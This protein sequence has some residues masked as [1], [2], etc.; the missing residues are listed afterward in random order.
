MLT[1]W[2][3]KPY[4]STPLT[5]ISMAMYLNLESEL[6]RKDLWPL[7]M[8]A[9]IKEEANILWTKLMFKAITL[10]NISSTIKSSSIL[11]ETNLEEIIL[12]IPEVTMQ[13]LPSLELLEGWQQAL[14]ITIIQLNNL[15]LGIKTLPSQL[16]KT[17]RHKEYWCPHKLVTDWDKTSKSSAIKLLSLLDQEITFIKIAKEFKISNYRLQMVM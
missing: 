3:P 16:I 12:R 13:H 11:K 10:G 14:T 1:W 5:W 4:S 15:M 2:G 8:G 17:S 7:N 6:T 9:A